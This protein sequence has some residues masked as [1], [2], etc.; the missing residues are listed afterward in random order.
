M[1]TI[2][3][4]TQTIDFE[5]WRTNAPVE[6]DG[7]GTFTLSSDQVSDQ[8]AHGR[9]IR[10]IGRRAERLVAIDKLHVDWQGMRYTT[11]L[12]TMDAVEPSGY[13]LQHF[14]REIWRRIAG[15]AE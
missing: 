6:L 12:Y 5:I 13:L 7:F 11:A 14:E 1:I 2:T 4:N 10:M 3:I 8:A 15:G 9:P